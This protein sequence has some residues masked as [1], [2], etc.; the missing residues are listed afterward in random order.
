[1]NGK[2]SF[3]SKLASVISISIEDLPYNKDLLFYLF[4]Q[5]DLGRKVILCTASHVFLAESVAKHL[6]IFN[7]VLASDE[8]NNLA[9]LAKAKALSD[10][11]GIKGFDYAGNSHADLPENDTS[12]R[13]L[14][15]M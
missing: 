11:Y 4:E 5:R 12:F 8:H 10:L 3:K 9:G 1:L 15:P 7:E 2:A 13:L 14:L 6:G